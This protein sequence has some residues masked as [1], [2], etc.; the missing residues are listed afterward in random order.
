MS[1]KRAAS[2]TLAEEPD[3]KAARLAE[4]AGKEKPVDRTDEAADQEEPTRRSSRARKGG[5]KGKAEPA[6]KAAKGGVKGVELVMVTYKEGAGLGEHLK[7]GG[8]VVE[9]KIA[10]ESTVSG[11]PQ[12]RGL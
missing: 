5:A 8:D 1:G 11:N 9:V 2:E 3:S 12:V 4:D 6:G 7:Q 10:A